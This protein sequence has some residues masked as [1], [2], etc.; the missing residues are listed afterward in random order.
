MDNESALELY[1]Q[2]FCHVF[3][4]AA[5]EDP[6][7]GTYLIVEDHEEVWREE[8]DDCDYQ[9]SILHVFALKT[10]DDGTVT[11]EDVC[12]AHNPDEVKQICNAFFEM[13]SWELSPVIAN[14]EELMHLVETDDHDGPLSSFDPNDVQEAREFIAERWTP[15]GLPEEVVPA[16]L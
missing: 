13:D 5:F 6:S 2:G 4:M 12:G 11:I 14:Y 10:A 8:D 7:T 9:A 3:A 16:G 15:A 1:T